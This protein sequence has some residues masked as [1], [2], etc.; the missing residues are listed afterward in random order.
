MADESGLI[1]NRRYIVWVAEKASLN[2]L[3]L[4]LLLLLLLSIYTSATKLRILN[5]FSQNIT[6]I[7]PVYFRPYSNRHISG[8]YICA[9]CCPAYVDDA[10]GN[11]CVAYNYMIW[12]NS[13]CQL[14]TFRM[15]K[16]K[17]R[18][19]KLCV[20]RS[21]CTPPPPPSFVTSHIYI[22]LHRTTRIIRLHAIRQRF[23]R[24]VASTRDTW[25]LL[26][27]A[28]FRLLTVVKQHI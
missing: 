12:Y 3:L 11:A 10:Y 4:L 25:A 14:G 16:C 23:L 1:R 19:W 26:P 13:L 8:P 22:G 28:D 18:T 2:K 15:P 27:H 6:S 20:S 17:E 24:A 7:T 9:I 5:T 21:N